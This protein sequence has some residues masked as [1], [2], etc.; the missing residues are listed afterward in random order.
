MSLLKDQ[1]IGGGAVQ[2]PMLGSESHD[3]LKY[4]TPDDLSSIAVYLR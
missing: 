3:S 2:G 4:L 1:M